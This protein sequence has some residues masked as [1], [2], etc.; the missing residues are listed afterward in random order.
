F[1][2]LESGLIPPG[3]MDCFGSGFLPAT[4]QGTL[5]RQGEHPVADLARWEATAG[6]QKSKLDL[7]AKLNQGVL[8]R[9]GQVSEIDASIKNYELAFRMQSAVPEL[10]DFSK[11]T[12]ATKKLYGLDEEITSEFGRECLIARRLV[13]RGV[14]FIELL[15]PFRRGLD[16]WDQHSALEK[17]HR[18]NAQSV[19]KP[20]AGLLKD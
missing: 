14:R 8:R 3:G 19:D 1:V 17:G 9:F 6:E 16:R 4:Y 12:E 5:F 13:E 20:I 7:L 18:I 11:E 10:L 15:T 2:V